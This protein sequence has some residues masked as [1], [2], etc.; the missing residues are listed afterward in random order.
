VENELDF[1]APINPP[2]PPPAVHPW[3]V[4]ALPRIVKAL[5]DAGYVVIKK[6]ALIDKGI[7]KPRPYV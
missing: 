2:T 1:E 6:P 4:W 7:A 3:D 5:N